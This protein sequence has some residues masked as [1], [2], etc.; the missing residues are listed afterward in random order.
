MLGKK[1]EKLLKNQ[2]KYRNRAIKVMSIA[3]PC[4]ARRYG[5]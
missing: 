1:L 2:K 3:G 4:I 5:T